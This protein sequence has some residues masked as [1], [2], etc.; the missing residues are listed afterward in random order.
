MSVYSRINWNISWKSIILRDY[1][2]VEDNVV[3]FMFNSYL[4]HSIILESRI[5][6]I[7]RS[8]VNVILDKYPRIEDNTVVSKFDYFLI[9]C[10]YPEL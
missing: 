5:T 2:R 8:Q 10:Y 3:H 1:P 7:A 6:L 9:Y 4:M